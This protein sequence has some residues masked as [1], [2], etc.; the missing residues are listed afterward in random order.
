MPAPVEVLITDPIAKEGLGPLLDNPEFLVHHRP[1]IPGPELDDLLPRASALLVRSETKVTDALLQKA[2]SLKL[3]GRAGVGVDNIDLAAASRRG[4]LVM[5]VPGANTLA[6][7]EHAFALLLALARNIPQ[8]HAELKAG[9]W[10]RER[11][12][13]VE[14]AGKTLGV[15]G[16]GRI[17]REVAKRGLAFAMKVV[18][19]DPFLPQ[20]QIHKLGIEPASLE[21]LLAKADFVTLHASLTDG[22]RHLIN[23]KSLALMKPDARLV[24]CARG[25]LV[26]EAALAEALRSGRLKGAALDVFSKEPLPAESPLLA[27]ENLLVTP[28]LGAST[29]EAQVKVAA[30]L[31]RNVADFFQVGVIRNAVNLPGFEAETLQE[32]GPHLELADRLGRFAGQLLTGGLVEVRLHCDGY[33]PAHRHPIAVGALKGLLS[34]ILDQPGISFVNA[35][36]LAKERGIRF[37]ESA[38]NAAPEGYTRLLTLKVKTEKETETVAGMLAP[39]GDAWLVRLGPLA[40]DVVLKGKMLV[41]KN[42]DTPG[43]IGRVGTIL[44]DHKINI[45]DMRVGRRSAHGEAV[46]VITIDEDLSSAVRGELERLPGITGVRWVRL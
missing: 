9:R 8:A 1:K 2:K 39:N 32:L 12:V 6:A 30:E 19:Y 18:G 11:F 41:L 14:L 13:G 34:V 3:V 43:M 26:D 37:I 31:A 15:V 28:H 40:V 21:D 4:I 33:E 45:A 16:L 46:M 25:E 42:Q 29:E 5:N 22:T 24:N 36:L 10:K 38:E 27:L 7:T 17:G 35:A 20:E 44:G 23:A